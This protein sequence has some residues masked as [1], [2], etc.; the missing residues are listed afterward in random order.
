MITFLL[1]LA[2]PS[3]FIAL[4]G[5]LLFTPIVKRMA[6]RFNLVD[7][8]SE[9][10]IHQTAIPLLGGLALY[11]GIALSLV[12]H[13]PF[14]KTLLTIYLQGHIYSSIGCVGRH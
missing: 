9:R 11:V 3:F 8:P 5:S 4:L 12:A 1:Y 13:L 6:L 14:D 2:L 10:K 7:H